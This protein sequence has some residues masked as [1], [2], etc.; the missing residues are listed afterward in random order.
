MSYLVDSNKNFIKVAGSNA[1]Y[2]LT[3]ID[4]IYLASDNQIV[5]LPDA[6]SLNKGRTYN[7]KLNGTYT[8]GVTIKKS[9]NTTLYTID[10]DYGSVNIVS[11]GSD[12]VVLADFIQV[13]QIATSL[14]SLSD[15]DTVTDAPTNGQSL[16][17]DNA[18]SIWK[19]GTVS[20]GS[21][22][23]YSTES[24]FPLTITAPLA[25][26][27]KIKYYL[28]NGASP[29]TVNLPAV[30]TCDGLEIVL[31]RLGTGTI[32]VDASGNET[33]DGNETLT[34]SQLYSSVTLT[35]TSAGWYIE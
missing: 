19:P 3:A 11:T 29:V 16:V 34:I 4:E 5:Q 33:I 20:G 30:A 35:A 26:V 7:I 18:G 31:K 6:T 32:T 12:W 21:R 24:S 2:T 25:S 28:N 8:S 9:D 27:T 13:S 23:S 14:N 15:V 10:K 1:T 22:A 17:W